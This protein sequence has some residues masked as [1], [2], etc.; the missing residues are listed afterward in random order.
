MYNMSVQLDDRM[1]RIAAFQYI[2][3]LQQQHG[4]VLPW[5]ALASGFVFEGLTIH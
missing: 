1:V 5:S 4:D 3:K 2:V